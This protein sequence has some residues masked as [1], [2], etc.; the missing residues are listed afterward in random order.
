MTTHAQ[1][2][3][4][5][6]KKKIYLN[7]QLACFLCREWYDTRGTDIRVYLH[8]Y[9]SDES[10]L[11]RLVCDWLETNS[12]NDKLADSH[13]NGSEEQELSSAPSID[14]VQTGESGGN[15][16][17]RGDQTDGET[18][19]DARLLEEGGSV[20]EDEVDTCLLYTSPSPR[21]GLLSRMPSSA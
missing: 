8:A 20:V 13:T 17:A 2:P 4:E 5:Q 10:L 21:D 9:E 16:D 11:G 3:H 18:V 12:G 6:A 19:T 7:I 14:Q 1:G 15:V